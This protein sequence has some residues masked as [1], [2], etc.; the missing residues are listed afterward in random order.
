MKLIQGL[1]L[2]VGLGLAAAPLRAEGLYVL[3]G[4]GAKTISDQDFDDYYSSYST[5]YYGGFENLGEA[6][7]SIGWR[8]PGPFALEGSLGVDTG[9]SASADVLTGDTSDLYVGPMTTFGI[10][11][12]VCWDRPSWWFAESGVTELGLRVEGATV[13]GSETLQ[14]TDNGTQ[15]FSGSTVGFGIFVRA[16][17]IWD[18]TGL[19]VGLELGFDED[20]FDTLTVSDAKGYFAQ[21][22]GD[23]LN[24]YNNQDAYIDNSGGYIRLIIGW[25]QPSNRPVPRP[26]PY[27]RRGYQDEQDYPPAGSGQAPGPG[28]TIPEEQN[29]GN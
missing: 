15:N 1:V 25:S 27:W 17:N 3:G 20:Y 6:D 9:R 13:S 5:A 22:N 2:L 19:N 23:R 12:V 4:L 26:R 10:G 8:F 11:P 18:P 7:L 21:Y 24:N 14:G 29:Y 28:E 16:L